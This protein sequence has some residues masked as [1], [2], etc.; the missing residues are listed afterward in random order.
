MVSSIMYRLRSMRLGT[1]FAMVLLAIIISVTT[2]SYYYLYQQ[3]R[4]SLKEELYAKGKSILDF[5]D[6]L[7]ESRNEKFFNGESSEIPQQI[8]NDVL[9]RFTKVSKGEMLFKQASLEPMNPNNLA[10]RFEKEE[11]AWFQKHKKE[12]EHTRFISEG[13]KEFFMVSRPIIAEQRCISCHPTWKAGEVI[14]AENVKIDLKG[15]HQDLSTLT[16]MMGIA[17]FLN[18]LLVIGAILLLFHREVSQRLENLLKAMR[19]IQKGDFAIDDILKEEHVDKRKKNEIGRTFLSLKEMAEGIKPVIDKVVE[20]SKSVAE[21]ASFASKQVVANSETLEEQNSALLSAKNHTHEILS[22]N[23]TLSDHLQTLVEESH[24][25]IKEIHATKEAIDQSLQSASMTDQAIAQTLSAVEALNSH[26]DEITRTIDVISDIANETNLISLNAAIEAARAGEHGRGFAVV[27]DK[28]R[29]LADVSLKNAETISQIVQTMQ[30]NISQ[31][32][33]NAA[34]TQ[35]SFQNLVEGTE[36][37]NESF[38]QTQT[39]LEKSVTTMDRFGEDFQKQSEY[40]E[41]ITRKIEN[42]VEKSKNVE[43]NSQRITRAVSEIS[44]QSGSLQKLS[45]GFETLG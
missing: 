26:S 24:E 31:V 32:A 17:W 45:E 3:N 27:A 16:R 15:F 42:V 43:Q 19:R 20:E 22:Q 8:Q 14:A 6:M 21:N 37:I 35:K 9:S 44:S 25:T 33:K 4:A 11:I 30:Q 36:E 10:D 5:A 23:R 12:K 1:M 29:E 7:F 13:S 38:S 34:Q 2:I 41:E 39:V 40:L 18:I 28:V